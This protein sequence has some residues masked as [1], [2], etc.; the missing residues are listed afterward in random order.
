MRREFMCV[1]AATLAW[2][3]GGASPQPTTAA[4]EATSGPA[5]T[6][7]SGGGGITYAGGDGLSCNTAIAIIGAHGES[8]GVESE[9]AWIGSHYP[10]AKFKQQALIECGGLAAD[11]MEIVS[12]EGQDIVLFFDI[13]RFFGKL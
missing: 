11:Q 1:V 5:E 4:S 13:S 7:A 12:A 10:G 6:A 8:D 2:A 9:Y 3:C